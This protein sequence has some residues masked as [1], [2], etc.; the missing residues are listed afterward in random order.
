VILSVIDDALLIDEVTWLAG[1]RG[2]RTAE[3]IAVATRSGTKPVVLK[4]FPADRDAAAAEWRALTSVSLP[5]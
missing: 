1:G 2:S 3:R 5:S 4:R